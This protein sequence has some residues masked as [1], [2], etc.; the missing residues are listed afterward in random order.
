MFTCTFTYMLVLSPAMGVRASLGLL[1]L[2]KKKM[3]LLA[4]GSFYNFL[5]LFTLDISYLLYR[6]TFTGI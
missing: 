5:I 3:L 1:N 6:E 4:D 2:F